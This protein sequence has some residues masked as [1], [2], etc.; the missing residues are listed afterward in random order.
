MAFSA[1]RPLD[2]TK[3][4]I[5]IGASSGIGAA[6]V[7]ELAQQGYRVAALA[8]RED[9]LNT[10]CAGLEQA[11]AYVHD[12]TDYDA[13]PTLF[14]QITRD[15]DGLDL[16]V[17]VAG[18]QPIVAPDEYNFDKDRQM[19][20]INLLGAMA[21]LNQAALRFSR[22]KTGQIVGISSVA[23]DRGRS[24]FPG[25]HTSKGAL[26]VYL[27]SLRNRLDKQ[28]VTVTTVKPGFVDTPLLENAAKT[29]WVIQPSDAAQQIV[30]AVKKKRQVIYV[31]GRWRW[32]MLIIMN[33]PSFVFRRLS[34]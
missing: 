1:S 27:E 15:L 19:I 33:I 14:N 8:R 23:G 2:G 18:V 21:W 7:T 25:Y 5:V 17:Y 29:F 6:I 30:S 32:V 28:G 10:L 26:N 20:E 31:P 34:I 9:K 3:K 13:V 24:A 12:V 16:V 11:R 22:A 4:A